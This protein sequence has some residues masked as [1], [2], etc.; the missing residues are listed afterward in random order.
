MSLVSVSLIL[1]GSCKKKIQVIAPASDLLIIVLQLLTNIWRGAEGGARSI[2]LQVV[3]YWICRGAHVTLWE[4]KISRGNLPS[5]TWDSDC[6][7]QLLRK[8]CRTSSTD[9]ARRDARLVGHSLSINCQP[10]WASHPEWDESRYGNNNRGQSLS[11][12]KYQMCGRLSLGANY[13]QSLSGLKYQIC[14]RLSLS[15]NY[16]E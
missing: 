6:D 3:Q 8:P 11:G 7:Q 13:N 1:T 2:E 5:W 16:R 10:A 15:A 4:K 12:L 14:G 9:W